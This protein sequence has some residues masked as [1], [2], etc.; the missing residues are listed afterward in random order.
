M[1]E[2]IK[3]RHQV[4]SQPPSSSHH[5]TSQSPSSS[6][7]V[8]SQPPSTSSALNDETQV[9]EEQTFEANKNPRFVNLTSH[10]VN[11]NLA[12]L[13]EKGPKFALTQQVTPSTLHTVEAG[14][15]RAFYGLKWSYT[16]EKL[17]NRTAP[18]QDEEAATNNLPPHPQSQPTPTTEDI[19]SS[20]ANNTMPR[21]FFQDSGARQP[22]NIPK[23]GEEVLEKIKSKI[24]N[25][26]RGI[27]KNQPA[28]FTHIQKKELNTLKQDKDKI[29]KRSGK[30]KGHRTLGIR[31]QY[32]V[33]ALRIRAI[34]TR[35]SWDTSNRKIAPT[36]AESATAELDKRWL[37]RKPNKILGV[38]WLSCATF[39]L[40]CAGIVWS[41]NPFPLRFGRLPVVTRSRIFY[42]HIARIPLIE[43]YGN[44]SRSLLQPVR[45]S[46]GH[47]VAQLEASGETIT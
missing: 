46:T 2:S 32:S 5:V 9:S 6:H 44:G 43:R 24:L 34:F 11:S 14:I 30:C 15:E 39:L 23:E 10:P 16:L 42:I 27:R 33:I 3:S 47:H 28:N 1:N 17:K 36:I 41:G 45:H 25:L 4:T 18:A 19:D 7:Q 20:P 26:Y 31:L 13:L 40:H 37:P 8:T 38:G 35:A 22:P 21:P 29:V 12:T